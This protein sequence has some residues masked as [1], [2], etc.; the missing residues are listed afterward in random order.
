MKSV[1]R[2]VIGSFVCAFIF[3]KFIT[4]YPIK[5]LKDDDFVND[6]SFV[7]KFWYM[8]MATT[9]IRFKYYHAW[10]LA[11]AICNNSGLGFNGYDKDGSAKWDLLANINVFAFEV[12]ISKLMII[13]V[14][15]CTV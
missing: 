14:G 6:T 15:L 7:Y 2:K 5:G 12:S 13:L 9:V 8:A 3:M 4:V 10:L 11:E 1:V